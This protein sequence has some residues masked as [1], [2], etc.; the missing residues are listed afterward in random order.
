MANE[1]A[2]PLLLDLFCGAGGA[3]MGYYR[4]GFDVLGVDIEPQ[5]RYPFQFV[6]G[7]ALAI[8]AELLASGRFSAAH[9]SPVC[10][11]FSAATPAWARSRHPN[12]IPPTRALFESAGLPWV[13]E[14]VPGAPVRADFKICGCVVGLHELERE[15]WFETNWYRELDLRPPC[16]HATNPIT[17]AGHGEPSGPRARRGESAKKADWERVMGIDWMNRDELAQAIP[18]AY[19]EHIGRELVG[20]LETAKAIKGAANNGA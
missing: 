1:G 5:S 6:Q 11:L 13:I 14:N 8:G 20:V 4:A 12:Q 10:K 15:R 18:P 9:G 16:Y 7:D 19:T 2:R 17:V 3:A